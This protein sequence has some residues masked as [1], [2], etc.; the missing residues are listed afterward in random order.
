[1]TFSKKYALIIVLIYALI[2]FLWIVFSD[3]ILAYLIRDFELY[4]RFQTYKG[5]FYVSATSLLLYFLLMAYVLRLKKYENEIRK[6]ERKYREVVDNATSIIL[7]WNFDGTISFINKFGESFFGFAHDELIG[8]NVIGTILPE[9]ETTGRDLKDLISSICKNTEKFEY[10]INENVKKNG[11]RVWIFWVN[12]VIYD[13]NGQ[14]REILSIGNDITELK[15]AHEELEKYKNHLEELVKER[16]YELEKA[17]EKLKELD[18]LKSMFIAS[19]SH[20]L[21]TPLNS[22]IGFSS[23]LLN[24][25]LGPLNDEQ[26][27]NIATINKAGKHLLA[28]INDVIDISKIEAGQIDIIAEEFELS[29]MITEVIKNFEIE[30]AKKG[31]QLSSDVVSVKMN[32]DRRRLFQCVMNLLSN[33]VKFTEKGFIRVSSQ[34]SKEK[35]DFVEITVQDSGIGIKEED[36]EKLFKPFQRIE[37]PNKVKVSATGLGLYITKK[38]VTEILKGDIIVESKYGV[39][40]KF[41]L[42]VP[43]KLN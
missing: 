37:I 6:S 34:I 18:R 19:V 35:P 22:I 27:L 43:I 7:R 24:E 23:I 17:N 42:K 36:L 29:D 21:R 39:G 2:G 11:E 12:K 9:R 1:M 38:I 31:L 26:K 5:W 3:R 41:I 32:T 30:I 33:A 28:L 14:A 16:T 13:E 8:K 4:T 40:S 15:R 20:E 25:W 10:N